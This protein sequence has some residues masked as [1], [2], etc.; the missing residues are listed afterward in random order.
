VQ[1][2]YLSDAGKATG[3]TTAGITTG[4]GD[5]VT[6]PNKVT[7]GSGAFTGGTFGPNYSE[8]SAVQSKLPEQP[9]VEDPLG[10][11]V[12]FLT[13]TLSSPMD[14]VGSPS[15]TVRLSSPSGTLVPGVA[16]QLMVFAKL[17]DVGPDGAVELPQRLISPVRVADP[18]RPVTIELPAIVHE[19]AQGHRLA[20]VLAGGD[21]AYRGA[22]V[23]QAVTLTT[24]PGVPGQLTVPLG[25]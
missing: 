24:G 17:Y 19:F 20:V 25:H 12:R 7:P 4:G 11:S 22:T 3:A 18:S 1:T 8:I 23:P 21:L 14:V 6:A 2:Y 13:S 10:T 9:P 15:L 16:S 5:L